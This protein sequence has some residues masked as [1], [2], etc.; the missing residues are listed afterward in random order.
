MQAERTM[1]EETEGS[2][3][4]AQNPNRLHR[5]QSQQ[6]LSPEGGGG[7]QATGTLYTYPTS[8]RSP[9]SREAAGSGV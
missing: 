6:D 7:P 4:D 9:E 1:P 3:G 2:Q 8:S 5:R